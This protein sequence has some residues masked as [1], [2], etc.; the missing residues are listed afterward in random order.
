MNIDVSV[1]VPLYNAEKYIAACVDSVLSQ[2]MQNIEI[3]LVDDCS[4]DNSVKL[5]EELYGK[6]DKVRIIRQEK[7]SGPGFA[8][9]T[10]IKNAAGKYIAFI[11]SDDQMKHD[12]LSAMFRTAEKFN[13]DVVHATGFLISP[14]DAPINML[15]LPEEKLSAKS[16]DKNPAQEISLLNDD[17]DLRFQRWIEHYYHCLVMNKLYRREF[18]LE[19]NIFFGR[20]PMAEDVLFC[21]LCLFHA[22][23][24]VLLPLFSYIYRILPESLSRS[25]NPVNI[26][27]K[28][29]ISYIGVLRQVQENVKS[30]PFF[31]GSQE[32]T[33]RLLDTLCFQFEEFHVMPT[34]RALDTEELRR[35]EKISELFKEYFNEDAPFVKR[36]FFTACE[37]SKDQ[38]DIWTKLGI[39][40]FWLA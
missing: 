12:N 9:N 39:G 8:R 33:Q 3:I 10:G 21:F 6:N 13:A 38:P 17:F 2:E 16:H 35:N 15:E 5:C 19:H 23:N 36:L 26:L 32:K 40:K 11:D 1:I 31:A 34:F 18:M 24:Y 14:T 28:S 20:T 37:L 22:K 29:L 7:N 25:K 4:T 30:I 27:L